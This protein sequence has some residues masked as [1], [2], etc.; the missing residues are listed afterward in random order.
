MNIAKRTAVRRDRYTDPESLVVAEHV[1]LLDDT[2]LDQGTIACGG[3]PTLKVW[4]DLIVNDSTGHQLELRPKHTAGAGTEYTIPVAA[5]YQETIGDAD[6]SIVYTYD[7]SSIP[8]LEVYTKA[9]LVGI[10][11]AKLEAAATA[12][13]SW[14]T[15]EAITDGSFGITLYGIEYNIDGI[16]FS[17]VGSMTAVADKVRDAIRATTGRS[18]LVTWTGTAFIIFAEAS[19][20]SSI[21]HTRTSTGTVGTDLSGEP[22]LSNNYLAGIDNDGTVTGKVGTTGTLTLEYTKEY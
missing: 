20:D 11:A 5:D 2:W 4:T 10:T 16:D 19:A 12:Q 17:G 22:L 3:F 7:V 9:T 21:T 6:L 14:A 1:G 8:F 18:E 13:G 15:W